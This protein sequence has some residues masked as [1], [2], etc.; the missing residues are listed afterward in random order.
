MRKPEESSWTTT[1]HSVKWLRYKPKFMPD[2]TRSRRRLFSRDQSWSRNCR[3][4]KNNR[5]KSTT[6]LV[7]VVNNHKDKFASQYY[8]RKIK[9]IR[10]CQDV[11]ILAMVELAAVTPDRSHSQ[12]LTN[13]HAKR[14]WSSMRWHNSQ[15]NWNSKYWVKSQTRL[16]SSKW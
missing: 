16:I 12:D 15:S 4:A 3:K 5:H 11:V 7:L 2:R 6:Q 13:S 1:N 10:N 9:T 8:Q 14:R